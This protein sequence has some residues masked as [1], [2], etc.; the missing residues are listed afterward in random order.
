MPTPLSGAEHDTCGG[1]MSRSPLFADIARALRIAR[2]CDDHRLPTVD[3]LDCVRRSAAA[4]AARRQTRREWLTTVVRTGAA[5]AAA[6]AAAPVDRLLASEQRGPSADVGIVGAG[7]AG[8]ACADALAARGIA[9]TL[10]DAATRT[11][12]RCWSLRNVFPGQVGERGGE[13]IDNLHKTMIGYARRFGLALEDVSKDPGE[14]VYHLDGHHVPESAVIDEFREFVSAMRADLRRLSNEVTAFSPTPDDIALD[15]TSLLEY[16]DGGN[17][18]GLV[19]APNA[20]A[21]IIAAYTGEYG[22]EADE[23][24]CLNFL[25]FI[26]ADRRSKFRPFGVFSDERYHVVDGND[27]IV[28]GLTQALV[29]PV[30]AGMTLV[31]VRRTAAGALEL[32]FDTPGGVVTRV[33]DAVVLALPFSTL[34]FVTLDDSLDLPTA[35]RTA[36][37]QLGYGTNAKLLVGFE[38]RPW[39]TQGGNG[40]TYSDLPY[41]QITWETNAARAAADRAVLTD[42]AS[43]ARGAAM[44]A[45]AL[46]A[47]TGTFLDELD[48]VFPG[49]QAAARRVGSDVMAHI[50]HWPSNPLALGS[51][52]CYRPGQFT[53]LAGLE[54]QPAGNLFFAG[55]HTNSFYEWQG[56]MEGA[57]LSGVDAAAAILRMV[58]RA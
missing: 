9:A 2:F 37:D 34:R 35:Q 29:R 24:S 23:Q 57:A 18:A 38:S 48:K 11:G 8:L 4:H 32:T 56:F 58:R 16:L 21:A 44:N 14:V 13:F 54:G 40:T 42:Y 7:L 22:L 27:R 51:Y 39:L 50:E 5:G 36:I 41:L 26:H 17:R 45:A 43:G 1:F 20:R 3:G 6:A 47:E 49:A 12:G 10:Y 31:A 15:R 46:Q 19:A 28:E 55:E 25:L 33:H 53:T 52:T 30:E